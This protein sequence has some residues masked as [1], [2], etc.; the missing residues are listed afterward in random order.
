MKLAILFAMLLGQANVTCWTA[1]GITTCT[2]V[3]QDGS[4]CTTVCSTFNGVTSCYS[5]GSGCR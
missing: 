4:T 1:N 3:N 2:T 5:Y